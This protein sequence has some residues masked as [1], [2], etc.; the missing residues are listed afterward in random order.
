M[1]PLAPGRRPSGSGLVRY[2][3]LSFL[4]VVLG[5]FEYNA[6]GSYGLWGDPAGCNRGGS[7]RFGSPVGLA[8]GQRRND[9]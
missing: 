3:V 6:G 2:P 4:L 1:L 5:L 8:T 7:A 9:G